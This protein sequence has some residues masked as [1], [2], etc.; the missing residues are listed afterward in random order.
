MIDGGIRFGG[1][2]WAKKMVVLRTKF[3]AMWLFYNF[4]LC[5]VWI[6]L[7]CY[8]MLDWALWII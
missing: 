1:S 2:S 8:Y 5:V 4:F 6:W 3:S 7:L